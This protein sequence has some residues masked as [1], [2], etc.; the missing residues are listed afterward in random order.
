[1][2]LKY[3]NLA[4]LQDHFKSREAGLNY[5]TTAIE[6]HRQGKKF[7]GLV[8]MKRH[9]WTKFWEFLFVDEEWSSK[10]Q[11]IHSMLEQGRDIDMQAA[12]SPQKAASQALPSSRAAKVPGRQDSDGQQAATGHRGP[13]GTGQRGAAA[14]QDNDGQQGATPKLRRARSSLADQEAG[15]MIPSRS[16]KA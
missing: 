2:G 12:E 15:N 4:M 5:A 11:S 16:P 14:G 8:L 1:M 3:K 9:N 6:A 13:T 7:K 10:N